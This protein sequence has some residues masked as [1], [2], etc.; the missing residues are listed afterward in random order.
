[1]GRGWATDFPVFEVSQEWRCRRSLTPGGRWCLVRRRRRRRRPEVGL[2]R[3]DRAALCACIPA[4]VPAL[5]LA[6][7]V[8]R[9]ER[10][11]R[12]AP[13]P[14]EPSRLNRGSGRVH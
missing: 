4:V 12:P 3:H 13:S 2:A 5:T 8:A 10:H 9:E 14:K 6:F 7:I 11:V 1:M